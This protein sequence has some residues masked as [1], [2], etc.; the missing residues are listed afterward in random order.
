MFRPQA[1]RRT[2]QGRNSE[3]M[4]FLTEVCRMSMPQCLF[5]SKTQKN[6][7]VR[8]RKD[9]CPQFWGRK[10]LR[11][12]HGHLEKCALSAGK[13]HA[14]KFLVFG[15]GG[16]LGFFLGGGKCR[17]YFYG[18]KDFSEF[19]GTWKIV[20]YSA[21][22][23]IRCIFFVERLVVKSLHGPAIRAN[24]FA[25]IES[26]KTSIFITYERFAW[27]ASNLRFAIFSPPPDAQFAKKGFSLGTLKGFARIGPSKVKRTDMQRAHKGI[28]WSV[29]L[30]SVPKDGGGGE[31]FLVHPGRPNLIYD[32]PETVTELP[33]YSKILPF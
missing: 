14:H 8:K 32:C 10:W 33:S 4:F 12:F 24:W 31:G 6:P 11:Q 27:I 28:G 1:F 18:R 29:C 13:P 20:W 2:W 25:R 26:Q 9:F 3:H 15:G 19:W 30:R 17:F 7:S 22:Y 23:A 16:I 21:R 5:L